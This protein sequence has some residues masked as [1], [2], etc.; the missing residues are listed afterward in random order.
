VLGHNVELGRDFGIIK[1]K[2]PTFQGKNDPKVYL[3]CKKKVECIFFCHN[4][5][6]PKKV[7]F[8]MIAF[9]DYVI[10]WWDQLVTNHK[11]NYE[12]Q[13]DY[14]VKGETFIVRRELNMHV[15]VDD[16]EGQNEN[17]FHTRCH[18]H[19]KVC[20]LI[21]DGGGCTNV[22]SIKL[23]KRLNLCSIKRHIPYKL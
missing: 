2:I 11:K 20:N 5:S 9:V 17:I 10:V 13:V 4:Y 15:K 16:L 23:V 14:S 22:T 19:N 12:R 21:I 7:K 1:L 3:E 6:E 8:V 18:I